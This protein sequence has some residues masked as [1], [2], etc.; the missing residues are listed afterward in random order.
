MKACRTSITSQ[1][2]S[3]LEAEKGGRAPPSPGNLQG[4]TTSGKKKKEPKQCDVVPS[5]EGVQKLKEGTEGESINYLVRGR[6]K[7]GSYRGKARRGIIVGDSS[8][9]REQ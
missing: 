6:V 3:H 7:Q 9:L 1:K 8:R 5:L 4:V 2:S